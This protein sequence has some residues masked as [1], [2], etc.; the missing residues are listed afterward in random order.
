MTNKSYPTFLHRNWGDPIMNIREAL[1]RKTRRIMCF[2][3]VAWL[4]MVVLL[5][6]APHG[7]RPFTIVSFLF[8]FASALAQSFLIRCPRCNGNVG[9]LVARTV[10]PGLLKTCVANC[11]FCGVNFDAHA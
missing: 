3:F 9:L 2:G 11:P 8:F 6:M 7:L 5:V 1:Q 10:M 4:A